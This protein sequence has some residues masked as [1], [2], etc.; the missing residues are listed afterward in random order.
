[1][2]KSNNLKLGTYIKQLR[3]E[4]GYS[5]DDLAEATQI[6]KDFVERI[7]QGKRKNFSKEILK[8]IAIALDVEYFEL[9]NLSKN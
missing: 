9:L 8:R 2:N 6:T 3:E 5:L 1:M 7:E 4:K